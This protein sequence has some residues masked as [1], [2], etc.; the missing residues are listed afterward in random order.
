MKLRLPVFIIAT[1]FFIL[2]LTS[3]VDAQLFSGSDPSNY[4]CPGIQN[5]I[6]V[7]TGIT[8]VPDGQAHTA[9]A[10]DGRFICRYLDTKGTTSTSDDTLFEADAIPRPQSL[11]VLQVW[12]VRLVYIVWG[13]SGVAFTGLLIWIGF[14]YMTSFNNEYQLGKVIEDLRKWAVGLGIVFLSYPFLVTFFRVLPISRTGCYADI[15]IP[16]FQFFFPEACEVDECL[17]SIKQVFSDINSPAAQAEYQLCLD[18][19]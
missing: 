6:P 19:Q 10:R 4:T 16:G 5:S 3:S 11:R 15:N 9:F 12:F 14:K 17:E 2:F 1:L 18:G 8:P 13:V 7:N